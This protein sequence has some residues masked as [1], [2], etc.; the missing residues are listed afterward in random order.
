LEIDG[1]SINDHGMDEYFN[2]IKDKYNDAKYWPTRFEQ[3]EVVVKKCP[4]YGCW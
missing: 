2:I 1:F 4:W 3:K